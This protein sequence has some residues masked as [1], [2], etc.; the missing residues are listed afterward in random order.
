MTFLNGPISSSSRAELLGLIATL[1]SSLPVHVALASAAVL[2]TAKKNCE[3]LL[4]S[5][6]VLSR[7]CSQLPQSLLE[8]PR[9]PLAKQ[10]P[11][12]PNSDW[13]LMYVRTLAT[14]G[15]CSVKLKNTTGHALETRVFLQALP[16]L[17]QEAQHNK[18]ADNVAKAARAHYHHPEFIK[19]SRAWARRH[20]RYIIFIRAVH[21]I[22]GSVHLATQTLR[23]TQAFGS[24]IT[25]MGFQT[26]S[27]SSPVGMIPH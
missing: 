26:T 3:Y 5:P 19:S 8:L 25:R 1:L 18:I 15:P 24:H 22:L 14:R 20:T 7:I 13:W 16:D 17:W 23:K 11:F 2:G 21:S 10:I 12:F 27:P 6:T 9:F 4:S